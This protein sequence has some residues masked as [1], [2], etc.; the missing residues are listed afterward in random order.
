MTALIGASVLLIAASAIALVL[1]WVSANESAIWTSIVASVGAA[2]ALA[3][4]FFRSRQE[5]VAVE[6]RAS[7]K[8]AEEAAKERTAAEQEATQEVVGIP[9]T[10]R[11]H[12]SECRYAS[13]KGAQTMTKAAARKAGMRPC[14]I[15]KP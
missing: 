5:A 1:G 11:F 15:C 2:V 10:K 9:D 7:A 12:R 6:R 14:G 8:E 13:S 3:L 4:A